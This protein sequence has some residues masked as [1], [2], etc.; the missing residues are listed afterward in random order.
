MISGG[1]AAQPGTTTT[2]GAGGTLSINF[3]GIPG[4]A[5][6]GGNG[7]AIGAAGSPGRGSSPAYDYA[8]GA[9]GNAIGAAQGVSIV[10]TG[11]GTTYA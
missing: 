11:T 6:F 5:L 2:G 8:G 1:V 4:P 9:K 3:G 10:I 7:G